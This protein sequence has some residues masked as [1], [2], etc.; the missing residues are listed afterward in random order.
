MARTIISTVGTSLLSNYRRTHPGEEPGVDALARYLKGADP[1]AASAETNALSSPRL[2]EKGDELRFI[3]SETADGR[4]CAEALRRHFAAQGASAGVAEA[5]G[6][7]AKESVFRGAG[8]RG[9]VSVI[10]QE[11]RAASRAGREPRINATGGF[12]AEVAYAALVGLL[13][14]VPVYYIHD[15]FREI[16]EMPPMPISWDL[17]VALDHEELLRRL[18]E[19][20]RPASEVEPQLQGLP[21]EARVLVESDGQTPAGYLLSV[22]G[23]VLLEAYDDALAEAAGVEVHLSGKAA[24]SLEGMDGPQQAEFRRL[25]GAL[26]VKSLW[27]GRAEKVHS[28]DCL[29]WPKGHKSE[30]MFFYEADDG[31]VR[32]CEVCLH[33]EYERL[34]ARPRGVRKAAY[35]DFAPAPGA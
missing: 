29:T 16:I 31:S 15:T 6:L 23:T 18:D 35:R 5:T 14:R 19:E 28:S 26:R 34:M 25:L 8:L 24:R 17:G 7:R 13:F 27:A 2:A 10:A 22:T 3:A 32:V 20:P 4:T 33:D 9:L 1:V 30:R 11:I 12:K 21:E